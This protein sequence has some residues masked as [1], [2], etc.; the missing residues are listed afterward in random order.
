MADK[1]KDVTKEYEFL[2]NYRN[3]VFQKLR[4]D[5]QQAKNDF[6]TTQ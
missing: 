4:A 2:P 5:D 6:D 3:A 1:I